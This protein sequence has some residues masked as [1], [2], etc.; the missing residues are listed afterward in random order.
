M[1]NTKENN[2]A[3]VL[4]GSA[5]LSTGGALDGTRGPDAL[6]TAR[7]KGAAASSPDR[8]ARDPVDAADPAGAT[9]GFRPDIEGMRAIAVLLVVAYH[10][11]VP[12]VSGGYVGVDVFFVLSGYLITGLLVQEALRTGRIDLLGFYARRARR[13]LPALGLVL[14]VTTAFG[15][16][17]FAPFEQRVLANTAIAAG[18]YLSNVWFTVLATDYLAADSHANPLLHTWSLGVEEQFYLLWPLLILGLLTWGARGEGHTR[19]RRLVW[20][21]AA[22]LAASFACAVVLTG[23]RQPWAFFLLPGRAWE[24]ALGALGAVVA[25]GPRVRRFSA[26]HAALAGMALIGVLGGVALAFDAHTRFP[27]PWAAVPALA[28]LGVLMLGSA[29]PRGPLVRALAV[30]PLQT[31]G[32]LSYGWYLWHW[33]VLAFGAALAGPLPLGARITLALAALGLAEL[34]YRWVE[35]PLRHHPWLAAT[36]RALALA[37]VI[38]LGGLCAG[39]AWRELALAW[40]ETPEQARFTRARD[41]LTAVYSSGCHQG[42]YAV[43][44]DAAACAAGPPGAAHTVVLMGDSHAAQWYPAFEALANAHGWRLVPMTK[45]DCPAVDV[46]KRSPHLGRRYFECEQWRESAL[47][48]L[49]ELRPDLTVLAS[50]SAQPFTPT[51]WREGTDRVLGRAAGASRAVVVLRDTPHPG[52]DVPTCLGRRAWASGFVPRPDCAMS[53]ALDAGVPVFETLHEAAAVYRNVYTLDLTDLL[54]PDGVCVPDPGGRLAYRDADHLRAS[55]A[56]DLA[57]DVA[58]RLAST[59]YGGGLAILPA[60]TPAQAEDDAFMEVVS[61]DPAFSH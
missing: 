29:W 20:A 52:F 25:G 56:R 55:F 2:P 11:G 21:L 53:G 47:R 41:D 34:S 43:Q 57:P 58:R 59:L 26:A 42:F 13:L 6:A 24:F 48:F 15:M 23:I 50:S 17:V 36:P 54:C 61:E 45:Y 3:S 14:V 7:A 39:A 35:H 44:V 1:R 49:E 4:A 18:A 22:V 5:H 38:T 19:H 9:A 30:P 12:G 51:Q 28:T 8:R 16:V 31:L 33:P 40:G 37:G 32:R 60:A 27:G 46:P 10:A